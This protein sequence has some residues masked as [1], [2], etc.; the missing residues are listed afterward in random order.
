[1]RAGERSLEHTP[2]R[3]SHEKDS[4]RTGLREK[5]DH[6]EEKEEDGRTWDKTARKPKGWAADW[7]LDLT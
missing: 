1:M 6:R 7:P 3:R 4:R 2:A 5:E